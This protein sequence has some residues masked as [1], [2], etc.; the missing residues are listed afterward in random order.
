MPLVRKDLKFLFVIIA[1]TAIGYI[2]GYG[3]DFCGDD[4]IR[5]TDFTINRD[6]LVEFVFSSMPERPLLMASLY[7][8]YLMSELNPISFK[9]FSILLHAITG[10]LVFILLRIFNRYKLK[11]END[12]VSLF[13]SLIFVLSPINSQVI[14]TVVQR[15]VILS[16]LFGLLSTLFAFKYYKEND[17]KNILLSSLMI[18]LSVLSKPNGAFF[19]IFNIMFIKIVLD[20]DLKRLMKQNLPSFLYIWFPVFMLLG[21]GRDHYVSNYYSSIEYFFY[22]ISTFFIYIKNFFEPFNLYFYRVLNVEN[23]YIAILIP[24]KYTRK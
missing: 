12:N 8:N 14:V 7:L 22:Q 3:G 21:V 18:L 10:F 24:T 15:G 19:A 1:T 20:I 23:V 6:S 13:A 5:I 16:T 4:S 17:R 2:T 11:I 9:V